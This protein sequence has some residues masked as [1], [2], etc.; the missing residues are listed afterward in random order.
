M[1]TVSYHC[2]H[3]IHSSIVA[4]IVIRCILLPSIP[5]NAVCELIFDK[6]GLQEYDNYSER[7]GEKE[8]RGWKD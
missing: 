3:K 5:T 4:S 6:Y 8:G 2:L 7:K 1:V